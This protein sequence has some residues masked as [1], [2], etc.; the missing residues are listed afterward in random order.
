MFGYIEGIQQDKYYYQLSQH[1]ISFR[2]KCTRR[3][4]PGKL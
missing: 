2:F 4:K 1:A 3:R